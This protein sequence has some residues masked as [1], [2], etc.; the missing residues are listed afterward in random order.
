MSGLG[1]RGHE[2]P[3]YH[4]ELTCMIR[5]TPA[6]RI[7]DI[8]THHVANCCSTVWLFQPVSADRSSGNFRHVLMFT[9]RHHLSLGQDAEGNAVLKTNHRDPPVTD[10]GHLRAIASLERGASHRTPSRSRG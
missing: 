9:D 8:V 7:V 2:V 3:E 6:Q 1:M 5:I 10:L 4:Q